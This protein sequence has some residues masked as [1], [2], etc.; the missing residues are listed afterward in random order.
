MKLS[1]KNK[2]GL[3]KLPYLFVIDESKFTSIDNI[4]ILVVGIINTL[5]KTN[6]RL[7]TTRTRNTLF[8]K[9]FFYKYNK[10]GNTIISDGWNVYIF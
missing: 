1:E 6:I 8:I 5:N 9:N 7:N 2:G 3:L 4:P 10:K